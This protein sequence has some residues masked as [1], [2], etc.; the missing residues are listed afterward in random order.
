M[1]GIEK[2]ILITKSCARHES[3]FETMMTKSFYLKVLAFLLLSISM[4]S[5]STDKKAE[6]AYTLEC[7]EDLL[8]F[9]TPE[10]TVT[11]ADGVEEKI[12][13]NDNDWSKGNVEVN[14]SGVT[15]RRTIL[16]CSWTKS[17]LADDWG[18]M[19]SMVVKY[20]KK[21]NQP[22]LQEQDSFIFAH[23]IS[24]IVSASKKEKK[25]FSSKNDLGV[26]GDILGTTITYQYVSA[27]MVNAYIDNLVAN[28]E[29][30]VFY[31]NDDGEIS[32]VK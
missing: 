28:P 15:I 20:V 30:K 21:E 24:C 31:V 13:I 5:C 32:E 23:G 22:V 19:S 9:V 12:V 4:V 2:L 8:K 17:I 11:N 29:K 27:S 25:A 3:G 26:G 7:S 16:N 14:M 6:F 18:V 1:Y 10:V